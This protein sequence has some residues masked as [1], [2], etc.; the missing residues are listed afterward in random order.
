MIKHKTASFRRGRTSRFALQRDP[1][2]LCAKLWQHDKW[3]STELLPGSELYSNA[4][5][6]RE[7]ERDFVAFV[8]GLVR[9]TGA[10]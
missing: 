2:K 8:G 5:T 4:E 6:E 9:L 7:R 3:Q 1:K 10:N